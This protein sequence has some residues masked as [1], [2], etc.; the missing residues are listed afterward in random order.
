MLFNT[1]GSRK[2]TGFYYKN[3]C[4]RLKVNKAN[5]EVSFRLKSTSSKNENTLLLNIYIYFCH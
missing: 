4:E 3:V 5:D 1:F 2:Y